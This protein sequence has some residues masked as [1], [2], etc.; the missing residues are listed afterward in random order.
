MVTAN[1]TEEH[2]DR[3]VRDSAG[4]YLDAESE[5]ETERERRTNS[6]KS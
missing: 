2:P 5:R 6:R 3:I 4:P 1:G